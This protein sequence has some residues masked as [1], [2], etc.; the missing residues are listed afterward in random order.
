MK[1]LSNIQIKP[2]MNFL[3]YII[4]IIVQYSIDKFYHFVYELCLDTNLLF[5]N[6]SQ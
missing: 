1:K 3:S 4:R 5:E 2:T 6:K